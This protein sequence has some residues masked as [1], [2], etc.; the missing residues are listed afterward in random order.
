MLWKCRDEDYR[1]GEE[2]RLM[3][4]EKGFGKVEG[5]R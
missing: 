3:G 4:A 2:W 5:W 1:E